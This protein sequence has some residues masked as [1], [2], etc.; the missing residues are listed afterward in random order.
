MMTLGETHFFVPLT[1]QIGDAKVA[2]STL[3]TAISSLPLITKKTGILL[4]STVSLLVQPIS[5][6]CTRRFRGGTQA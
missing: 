2:T 3:A 1:Q 5:V 4:G 6:T